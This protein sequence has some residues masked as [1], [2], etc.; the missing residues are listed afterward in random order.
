MRRRQLPATV[1]V[2]A[3]FALSVVAVLGILIIRARNGDLIIW[4]SNSLDEPQEVVAKRQAYPEDIHQADLLLHRAEPDLGLRREMA[5]EA[6]RLLA[7]YVPG[8]DEKDTRGFEWHYLWRTA[9]PQAFAPMFVTKRTI[10]AH[11][12]VAFFVSFSPNGRFVATASDDKTARIWDVATGKLR[13]AFSGHTNDVNCVAFSPDGKTLATASD[14]GTVRLWNVEAGTFREVI[15][16]HADAII[17]VAFNPANGQLACAASDGTLAI[18]D[19]A[20]SK[21]IA[22]ILAHPGRQIDDLSF[23]SDGK[24]LATAGSDSRARLWD[25]TANYRQIAEFQVPGAR[26]VGFS[27][28]RQLLAVGASFG[29][30]IYRIRSSELLAQIPIEGQKVRCVQF[31]ED[32]SSLL[33]A[34]DPSTACLA[35][36]TTGEIWNPF[37]TSAVLWCAA[38]SPNGKLVATTDATGKLVLWDGSGVGFRRTEL[39]IPD[40]SPAARLAISSQGGRIVVAADGIAAK[41]QNGAGEL[42]VWDVS[43]PQPQ[44]VLR[45]ASDKAGGQFRDV[46]FSPDG[47]AIAYGAH[48]R[49]DGRDRIRVVDAATGNSRFEID[50]GQVDSLF[51][52]PGGSMLVSQ[53]RRGSPATL[54]LQ[55]RDART[56][57]DVRTIPLR[58]NA[59]LSAFS[60]SE[61]LFASTGEKHDSQID[62]YRLPDEKRMATLNGFG[63]TIHALAITNDGKHLIGRGDGGYIAVLSR[64]TGSIVRQFTVSG[65]SSVDGYA[66][67]A[68]PD[69]RALALG[70]KNAIVL[71]DLESGQAMCSLPFPAE[72]KSVTTIAFASDGRTLAANTT[73]SQGHCGVYLWQVPENLVVPPAAEAPKP[74]VESKVPFGAS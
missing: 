44:R 30:R 63:E 25:P 66:M 65:V 7:K 24:M 61:N 29:A 3:F 38:F 51:Y 39:D 37:A 31:S 43:L 27:H 10:S 67:T 8:R 19:C 59:A 9:H 54:R 47:S 58:S 32:D 74:K 4:Q 2:A 62:L 41:N 46:A 36:L 42:A 45:L 50:T 64:E 23:S 5:N 69:G 14:D 55:I 12:G 72:M 52:T 68:S 13:V 48:Q 56:G 33:T 26:S 40:G 21:Q 73:T 49:Q 53:E 20:S 15:W 71:A 60:P 22:T 11:D 57:A 1:A 35:D 28:D 17:G 16:K 18:F 6:R 70:S 34:G